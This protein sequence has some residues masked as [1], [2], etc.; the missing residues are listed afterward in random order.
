[1]TDFYAQLVE[2]SGFDEA[3][4]RHALDYAK[5]IDMSEFS[6]LFFD[7]SGVSVEK[8]GVLCFDEAFYPYEFYKKLKT[9]DLPLE[10]SALY[11][12]IALLPKSFEDF[13]SRICEKD[14]FFD[15]AKRIAEGAKEYF[16]HN[17]IFGLYDYHFLANHVRGSILRLGEFEYQY[18]I[19]EGKR[20]IFLH[21]SDGAD[22][23]KE[24]RLV[25]YR[26]A[27]KYFGN[28][29]IIGDSWLL[30][31]ENKKML[32]EDSKILDFMNDFDVVST[33]ETTDYSELFHIF[34][35]I[36]DYSYENLPKNTSLQKAYAERVKNGLPIGSG[37]G[38]LRY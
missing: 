2:K 38:V 27:R 12:Y 13:S 24:S 16:A 35:R 14:I 6:R 11:V 36:S 30:Y 15:T 25:S 18:G 33:Y 28:Y 32:S 8:T 23:S 10:T 7:M 20:A 3:L 31:T 1:M 26:L 4:I 9:T 19:F 37:V 21:L 29:P 5:R 22:L 17:G 34:G